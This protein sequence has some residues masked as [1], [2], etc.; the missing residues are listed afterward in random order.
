MS[1]KARREQLKYI[2]RAIDNYYW[3]ARVR[4]ALGVACQKAFELLIESEREKEND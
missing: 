4:D 2:I 1:E 3:N